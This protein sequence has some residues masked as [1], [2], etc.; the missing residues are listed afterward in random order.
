M[1][2][3]EIS[4]KYPVGKTLYVK[5]EKIKKTAFWANEHDKRV[6]LAKDPYAEFTPSGGVFYTENR[7]EAKYVEGWLFDGTDWH[8][9]ENGWDGW[10]PIDEEDL[11]DYAEIGIAYE[12]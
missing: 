7:V 11:E 9:A 10:E 3:E 6:F 1:T 8:V 5:I 12:F 2:Y 4:T